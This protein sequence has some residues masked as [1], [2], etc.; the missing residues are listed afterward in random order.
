MMRPSVV[1]LFLILSVYAS[2]AFLGGVGYYDWADH[3]VEI[4][5]EGD[6]DD[7]IEQ[8]LNESSE[9]DDGLID[10]TQ[11]FIV[12]IPVFGAAVESLHGIYSSVSSTFGNVVA[13]AQYGPAAIG[14]IPGVTDTMVT[15]L[16]SGLALI[17]GIDTIYVISGRRL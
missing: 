3:Q 4:Q 14:S 11:N 1:A 5:E 13:A 8:G 10:S 9:D 17:I 6:F 15:Y 2:A 12:N 7:T 16:M